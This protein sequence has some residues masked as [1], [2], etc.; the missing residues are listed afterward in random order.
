VQS[1]SARGAELV[2]GLLLERYPDDAPARVRRNSG[3]ASITPAPVPLASGTP[4]SESVRAQMA[5]VTN[6]AARPPTATAPVPSHELAT[7]MAKPAPKR[8]PA[9][10]IAIA[11]L[12]VAIGGVAVAI[13][14]SHGSSPPNAPTATTVPA[15][16]AIKAP[17]PSIDAAPRAAALIDAGITK[18]K[19]AP[20][21]APP[22]DAAPKPIHQTKPPHTGNGRGSGS[23]TTIHEIPLGG[24]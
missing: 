9:L 15:D 7:V 17:P 10:W 2:S 24:T 21:A 1:V 4:A 23:S 20:D 16:A 13:A 18:P 14:L 11:G 8:S 5:A 3:R 22:V 12:A 6:T 19:P